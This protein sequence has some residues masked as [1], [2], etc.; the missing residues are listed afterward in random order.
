MISL[1]VPEPL[2]SLSLLA[3]VLQYQGK[4]KAAEEMN[5]FNVVL[6]RG[7]EAYSSNR[8]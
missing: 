1:I 7:R 8:R 3:S 2:N 6:R 4:Y 5:R